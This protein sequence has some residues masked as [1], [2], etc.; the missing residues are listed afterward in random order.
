LSKQA[1][2]NQICN[3]CGNVVVFRHIHGALV[4]I[5]PSGLC[6]S[7]H[8]QKTN[9]SNLDSYRNFLTNCP[10]CYEKVFFIRHNGGAVWLDP[11]LGSPWNIHPCFKSEDKTQHITKPRELNEESAFQYNQNSGTV[12]WLH[13]YIVADETQCIVEAG[14]TGTYY[15]IIRGD[16]TA[17]LDQFCEIDRAKKRI[18]PFDNSSSFEIIRSKRA[19]RQN[20]FCHVCKAIVHRSMYRE[21]LKKRHP[22]SL[23]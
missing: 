11:P 22:E 10:L 18:S 15:L 21:H 1:T 2:G 5:H 23:T 7:R 14:H 17:L 19:K 9:V 4:P 16:A 3:K 8:T 13:Q 12:R 20:T 6:G